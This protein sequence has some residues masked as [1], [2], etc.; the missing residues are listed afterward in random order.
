MI[1]TTHDGVAAA[2]SGMPLA[3]PSTLET[4]A[5]GPGTLTFWWTNPSSDN[6][7][8]FIV[9]G[10]TYSGGT[11]LAAIMGS[12]STWQQQTI[13]LGSGSQLLKW[14][15][16]AL[17]S[18]GDFYCGYVDQVS[19]A[20]GATAPFIT[21]QPTSQSQAP[22]G[23][24]TFTVGTGGTPPLYQWQFNGTNISGATTS[25][26]TV[27]NVQA[28]NLG[29]YSVALTNSAGYLLSSNAALEL[30]QITGWGSPGYGDTAVVT[31]ATNVLAIAAGVYCNLLLNGDGTLS[32]WG[33]N[34]S[35]TM[36]VPANL[37]NV[38]AIACY[39][40][41]L[42]LKADGT[43]AAWGDVNSSYGETNVPTGMSNVVAI[44]AARSPHSLALKSDGTVAAW[45]GVS[46]AK[47]MCPQA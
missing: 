6:Q 32:S 19:Y 27:T 12:G 14:A 25:A 26:Y 29:N 30:G 4:T 5:T 43:V 15:Y 10:T 46:S 36:T 23:I 24:A 33:W 40:E 42:A 2:E 9:G 34:V 35:G 39:Q 7:L 8:S 41:S 21:S 38:I 11:T 45:G 44:A 31:G 13:Y 16:S 28:G 20:T 18:P 17:I 47:R 3:G 1:T 22:G 37:T